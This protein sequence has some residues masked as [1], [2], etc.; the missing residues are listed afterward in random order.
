MGTSTGQSMALARHHIHASVRDAIAVIGLTQVY[1]N[2]S[3]SNIEAIYSFP[4]PLHAQLIDLQITIG[5]VVRKGVILPNS[6]AQDQYENA[7]NDGSTAILL[8]QRRPGLFVLNL[9]NLMSDESAEI[10]LR[11]ALALSWEE[12]CLRISLPTTIASR[13]GSS[14]AR[15]PMPYEH[16]PTDPLFEQS[17]T[18][19]MEIAGSLASADIRSP[20][21]GISVTRDT[22]RAMVKLVH[23]C[24]WMDRDFIVVL[25]K[26]ERDSPLWRQG[27][28]E[29]EYVVHASMRVPASDGMA[30]VSRSLK[31]VIDCS[32]SMAGD[33]MTQAR[34]GA[35]H[36]LTM[37]KPV[38]K[39]GV[40]AYGSKARC[41]SGVMVPASG[42]NLSDIASWIDALD[43]DMG[44]A[45][46]ED[47]LQLAF[48]LRGEFPA[49]D[50]LLIS[51]GEIA[52]PDPAICAARSSGHRLFVVGV[53]ASPAESYLR[54]LCE[55]TNGAA[56]FVT[57]YE[58]MSA[59]IKRHFGKIEQPRVLNVDVKWPGDPLW[60]TP[61][62][63]RS[64]FAGDTAHLFAE[65]SK[66]VSGPVKLEV[67]YDDGTTSWCE[68]DIPPSSV[69]PHG[70]SH[71]DVR[72]FAAGHRLLQMQMEK[73]SQVEMDK[74]TVKFQLMT[75]FASYVAAV[76]RGDGAAV[77]I[78]QLK[79][80]LNMSPAARAGVGS[81]VIP[82]YEQRS[83]PSALPPSRPVKTPEPEDNL[84]DPPSIFDGENLRLVKLTE[85]GATSQKSPLTSR[86]A[87]LDSPADFAATVNCESAEYWVRTPSLTPSDYDALSAYGVPEEIVA[88]LSSLVGEGRPLRDVLL[89]FWLM[90]I[91]SPI[92]TLFNATLKDDFREI[93]GVGD[94]VPKMIAEMAPRFASISAAA[95]T[96]RAPDIDPAQSDE[97]A[98]A[99]STG[100]LSTTV[101]GYAEELRRPATE[102][103]AYFKEAGVPVTSIDSVI[104]S[105]H[106]LALLHFLR[107]RRWHGD[108]C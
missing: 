65:F 80:V 3:G 11:Y 72:R 7:V 10:K 97:S 83:V 48:S 42:A 99:V 104:T 41:Y 59:A 81:V 2:D 93:E 91:D 12:D 56:A 46:V 96:W 35:L 25:R 18:F 55:A 51:A 49:H 95:W 27:C 21:H 64:L 14:E 13:F 88:Y 90:L 77:Q 50:V 105:H 47:A 66:A 32:G 26:S 60:Y 37:L 34:Q 71:S 53:G 9:G 107:Q 67:R 75:P 68:I 24:L 43:A 28:D 16:S 8:E 54:P 82:S 58:D 61:P 19:E 17:S 86:D 22:D 102:L 84:L 39:I 101:A 5:D 6:T 100:P 15:G 23:G 1:R 40:V 45:A 106:K 76:S 38:D 52:D 79:R 108:L 63:P 87:W 20:T 36:V 29:G 103:L 85:S 78:P 4:L 98:A 94:Y 31:I 70:L 69:S 57:P 62:Q 89:A 33:A 73:A 30:K 92:G 44:G 74:L